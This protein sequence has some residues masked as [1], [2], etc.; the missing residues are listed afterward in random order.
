MLQVDRDASKVTRV[1]PLPHMFVVKV[2]R[3]QPTARVA[4]RAGAHSLAGVAKRHACG[5]NLAPT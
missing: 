1:A 2:R 5:R 4:R 3:W